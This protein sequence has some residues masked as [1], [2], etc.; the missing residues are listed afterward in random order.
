MW[1]L[2]QWLAC[3]NHC[4]MVHCLLFNC[5][6]V[7]SV[8]NLACSR[9][10]ETVGYAKLR[11]REYE[12]KMGEETGE[13][14]GCQTCI[15]S[16]KGLFRYTNSWYT[17]WLVSFFMCVS[18]IET[19]YGR[20]R[21]NIKVEP[22]STFAFTRGLSYIASISFTHVNFTRLPHVKITRQ[23]KSTLRQ[24]NQITRVILMNTHYV[25]YYW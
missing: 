12:N 19:M 14:K 2:S 11:K 3:R 25:F 13:R 18:E 10:K 4:I 15:I 1:A 24:P 21:V 6:H 17:L 9:F 20:S 16:F 7:S 5:L 8:K 22:R 23:C